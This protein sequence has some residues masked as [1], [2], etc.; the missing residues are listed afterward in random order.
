M[1]TFRATSAPPTELARVVFAVTCHV[2]VALVSSCGPSCSRISNTSVFTPTAANPV[3]AYPCTCTCSPV[4]VSFSEIPD[5]T[6][7]RIRSILPL[8]FVSSV[9]LATIGIE[10]TQLWLLL[11]SS[12]LAP[13]MM[14]AVAQL[15]ATM[16]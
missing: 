12:T 4:N 16:A 1:P 10:K 11:P 8:A 3:T 9:Q 15:H 2:G 13:G 5:W 7:T 14:E 6:C